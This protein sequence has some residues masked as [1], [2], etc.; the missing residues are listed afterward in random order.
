LNPLPEVL[1]L[2]DLVLK[3]PGVEHAPF[4]HAWASDPLVTKYL[5]FRPHKSLDETIGVIRRWARAWAESE[6]VILPGRTLT[7]LIFL[8]D[9]PVGSLG[10]HGERYGLELSYALARAHWGKGIVPKAVRGVTEWLLDHGAHRVYA[11]AHVENTASHRVLEKAGF[12][13]EGRLA[14]YFFFP[15]LGAY[16]D[17]YLY[18]RVE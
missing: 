18:A 7:Y 8:E 3:K 1:P 2:A 17:G 9:E 16:A 10:V 13:R 5:S 11:T 12:V 6:G 15:N 4:V 14:K